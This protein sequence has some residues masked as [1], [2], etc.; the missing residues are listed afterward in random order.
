MQQ[1]NVEFS[2]APG[3]CFDFFILFYIK[4]YI[5]V[6]EDQ[7]KKSGIT[8]RIYDHYGQPSK[9]LFQL[10]PCYSWA[11]CIQHLANFHWDGFF[12]ATPVRLRN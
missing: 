2:C 4:I 9:L 3:F 1:I 6:E 7:K 12:S 5:E 10:Q 8:E 11:D